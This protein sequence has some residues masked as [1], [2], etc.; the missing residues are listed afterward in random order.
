MTIELVEVVDPSQTGE[1]PE[2]EYTLGDVDGKD[3]VTASDALLALQA[4][5]DKITLNETQ[6]LA[7]DVNGNGKVTAED[8]LLILQ[9]TTQKIGSFPAQDK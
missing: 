2:P 5:T 9:F 4:A 1:E 8:A 6:K 3:G 7:A